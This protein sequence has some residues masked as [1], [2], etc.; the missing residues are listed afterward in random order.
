VRVRDDDCDLSIYSQSRTRCMFF[1]LS[2]R[3]GIAW[4]EKF[5]VYVLQIPF[6]RLALQLSSQLFARRYVTIITLY[7]TK[8]CI[9][10]YNILTVKFA[11]GV[12][13]VIVR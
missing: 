6:E 9:I 11:F 1:Y 7:Q 12:S 5:W 2:R 3:H 4:Y 13:I 10:I 8:P